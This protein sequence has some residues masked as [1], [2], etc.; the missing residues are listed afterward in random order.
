MEIAYGPP[1][2]SGVKHL[3]YLSADEPD[4]ARPSRLYFAPNPLGWA[5][6]ALA[7]YGMVHK[8]RGLTWGAAV[9]A[10]LLSVR[11]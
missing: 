6:V 4:V 5:A 1:G 8:R 11:A 9:A 3:Q 2:M 10:V 7:A